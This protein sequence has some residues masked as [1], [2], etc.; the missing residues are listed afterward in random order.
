LVS[1]KL[2]DYSDRNNVDRV[3]KRFNIVLATSLVHFFPPKHHLRALSIIEEILDQEPDN[4]SGLM[5]RG[6]ILEYMSKWDEAGSL[7]AQVTQ[8]IPE[9]LENGLSAKEENA[10]CHF[11]TQDIESCVT[12]LKNVL[13]VLDNLDDRDLDKARCLWRIGKCHW[14]MG[15]E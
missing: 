7:F 14:E 5:G 1:C 8:L 10:W 6:Y 3:E 2:K 15:G 9:D 4:I 11:Q 13:D 12:G